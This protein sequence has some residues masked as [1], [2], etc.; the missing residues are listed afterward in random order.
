MESNNKGFVD[1]V[2]LYFSFWV[3]FRL[4][5]ELLELNGSTRKT[6]RM[7]STQLSNPLE[8]FQDGSKQKRRGHVKKAPSPVF[9][10]PPSSTLTG[11]RQPGMWRQPLRVGVT[12]DWHQ[13]T[14]ISTNPSKQK[15]DLMDLSNDLRYPGWLKQEL[16]CHRIWQ[17]LSDSV[18]KF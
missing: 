13:Q 6:T 15:T 17:A 12:P 2:I 8:S 7:F 4:H 3:N 10:A 14:S 18:W 11:E 16:S 1:I 5:L 9:H